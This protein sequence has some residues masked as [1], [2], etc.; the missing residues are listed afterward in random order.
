MPITKLFASM[1]VADLEVAV[2][3]YTALF[4]GEPDARPMEG[5]VEWHL[6]DRFGVQVFQD[7]EN[8]GHSTVV[9]DDTDLDDR[10]ALLAEAGIENDGIR[11][12]TS[13][14]ILPVVDLDGNRI[15]FTGQ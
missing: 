10:L 6:D 5:L 4:A 1:N 3:W 2:P 9:L 8:A 13:S 12:A 14:R 11:Q 7:A 15:V